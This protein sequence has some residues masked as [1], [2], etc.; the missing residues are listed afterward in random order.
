[1]GRARGPGAAGSAP[2]SERVRCLGYAQP[3]RG[4]PPTPGSPPDRCPVVGS[5]RSWPFPPLELT[6]LVLAPLSPCHRKRWLCH[7]RDNTTVPIGHGTHAPA[8]TTAHR[9]VA[10][11]PAPA[12]GNHAMTPRRPPFYRKA[13]TF[14]REGASLPRICAMA[15]L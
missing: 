10:S 2:R 11:S 12:Q 8:C 1:P 6:C 15:C 4:T 14:L 13:D 7:F 3:H 9:E 5:V